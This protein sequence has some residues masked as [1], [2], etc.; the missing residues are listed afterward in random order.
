M[1]MPMNF[2]LDHTDPDAA[3]PLNPLID[4]A[5]LDALRADILDH[6]NAIELPA[7]NGGPAHEA[8]LTKAGIRASH[9][10]QR[11]ERLERELTAIGRR[12]PR[13]LSQFADGSEVDPEAIDP[14]LVPVE[15]GRD[16]GYLF[17]LAT[18]LWSVPVSS[19]Y[20]RRMRFLVR[21][22]SNGKLIGLFALG[23]PVFNLKAR[24]TWIGWDV[25]D[26]RARLVNVMDAYVVGAVPPYSQ[27]LGGKLVASLVASREVSDTF[28]ARY[29]RTR[30]II[31]G[32][33]KAA[34][35][36]LVTVTSALGRSSLYNR[37]RLTV[38][39]PDIGA[40]G[41]LVHPPR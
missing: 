30:G 41:T 29:N 19:G 13:L 3:A 1:Q 17:R 36:V 22:R 15:S 23:D 38:P 21:D 40:P 20:G 32:Q 14:E 39:D 33:A 9:S 25:N 6:L 26:R 35:L 31:S 28:S 37:L 2:P 4:Q 8:S 7:L 18:L 24:D 27:L 34:R 5:W 12:L 10:R 11:Q 16:T